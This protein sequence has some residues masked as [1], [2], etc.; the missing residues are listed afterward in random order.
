[1]S[2]VFCFFKVGG[3]VEEVGRV[4]VLVLFFRGFVILGVL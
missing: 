2:E 1:M 3:L 4:L